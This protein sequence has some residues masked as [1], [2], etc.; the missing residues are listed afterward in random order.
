MKHLFT[1]I[2]FLLAAPWAFASED[3][4]LTATS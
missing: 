3:D 4:D 2:A 1:L